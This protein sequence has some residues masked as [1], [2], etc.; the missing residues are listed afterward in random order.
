MNINNNNNNNNFWKIEI[1]I[2]Q[3]LK[4]IYES[5]NKI[6]EKERKNAELN[7]TETNQKSFS[8]FLNNKLIKK[9]ISITARD[10]ILKIWNFFELISI[11]EN[12]KYILNDKW[13]YSIYNNDDQ[14]ENHLFNIIKEKKF[15]EYE[16]EKKDNKYYFF[17]SIKLNILFNYFISIQKQNKLNDSK[18]KK[19]LQIYRIT[20]EDLNYYDIF[21]RDFL[22]KKIYKNKQFITNLEKELNFNKFKNIINW[23]DNLIN[24][25]SKELKEFIRKL[26]EK[27]DNDFQIKIPKY[28]FKSYEME[29]N[30]FLYLLLGNYDEKKPEIKRPFRIPIYQRRYVWD[31]KIIESLLNDI[32]NHEKHYIGN[33]LFAFSNNSNGGN[34]INIVDGQ[35]RIS[36]LFLILATWVI[37]L[38]QNDEYKKI[39]EDKISERY[40]NENIK[41]SFL[42]NFMN[43]I[44][45]LFFAK[46]TNSEFQKTELEKFFKRI[47]GNKDYEDFGKI[48]N[49]N[50]NIEKESNIY[51]CFHLIYNWFFNEIENLKKW[52]YFLIIF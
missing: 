37:F 10:Q 6:N 3:Y 9:E 17:Y 41:D 27:K 38:F 8:I 23:E 13:N 26:N 51:K 18:E 16:N 4:I 46:K 1:N 15:N 30:Y 32:L 36:T 28:D 19:F 49:F 47:E 35:Q 7:I 11:T 5:F 21:T 33:V 24:I 52:N 25:K 39:L 14:F 40:S 31:K 43:N 29:F 44:V 45:P 42:K 48:W 22:N 34:T 50:I 2:K 20:K 12:E